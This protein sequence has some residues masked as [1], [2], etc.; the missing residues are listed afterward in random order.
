MRIALVTCEEFPAGVTDQDAELVTPILTERGAEVETPVWTDPEVDWG[1]CDLA[2]ISSTWDYHE[3]P[4]EF[5]D[6]LRRA[7]KATE[8]HNP[9]DLVRWNMDKRYLREL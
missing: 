7:D 9:A 2:V 6:W 8:L 1:A 5:R 4:D 3:R